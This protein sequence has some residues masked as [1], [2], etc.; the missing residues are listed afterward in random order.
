MFNRAILYPWPRPLGVLVL[1]VLLMASPRPADAQPP[2][3]S[4]AGGEA[5]ASTSIVTR[6]S[7]LRVAVRN[8]DITKFPL[9]S[10][11]FD[12][13]D[14]ENSFIGG[15]EKNDI[16]ISENRE[17]QEVLSLA[18]ITSTNRVPIDFV[19]A[20]DQTGSMGDEIQGVKQNIDDFTTRLVSKGIDYRLGLV[21][22]DDNVANRYWLT[23]DLNEFKR[24]IDAIVV[25]GGGD[26]KENALEALRAATGMNFRSSANRC[27]VLI[28]D[29]PF[30]QYGEQGYGR[31]M[32]TPRTIT[33]IL[34]RFDMRTFCIVN[35]AIEG[36]GSIAQSTGGQTFDIAQ[37]FA[38]ILNR[39]VGT[40]TSL[41]TATY[42]SKADLLP[43]SIEV[44]L[45]L[46]GKKVGAKKKFA[47]LEIG[48]KLVVDNIH[49]ATNQYTLDAG[50]SQ[51]LDYL[52][53]LMKARPSLKL[54]I[55]GHT[56]DKGD[57]FYN[58]ELSQLRAESVKNYMVQSGISPKRLFT[59]G[60]GETRPTASNEIEEGRR[61]NRRTEFIIVQK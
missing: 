28:T 22:F 15:L 14:S 26:E 6:D 53:R 12:V 41:Y 5:L 4:D 40:M 24:W 35:P 47:V 7:T 34:N 17:E 36:Y 50:G 21:V 25:Q 58:M 18:L 16:L 13:F 60:Y 32:Y 31:T 19:F 61:L 48:R 51:S 11:I 57:H 20:I 1:L 56:D 39:F 46:P 10:I 49:F 43:D 33:T 23:D 38:D 2:Q 9:V 52:V 30:H 27:V 29:A 3:V 8:I 55:E 54:K 37:P 59:I 45:K 44:E 42:Q